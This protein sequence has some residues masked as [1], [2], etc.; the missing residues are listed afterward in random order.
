MEPSD[1]IQKVA[2][3]TGASSGI[4]AATASVLSSRG[5]ALV[6]VA[7]RAE[8][9]EAVAA[10]LPG[11][12]VVVAMD[13]TRMEAPGASIKAAMARFGRLDCL[14]NN[15]G[16]GSPKPLHKTSDEEFDLF[17]DVHLRA[18]FRFCREALTVMTA[19][20]SIVNLAS[21]VASIGGLHC[22]AYSAAKAGVIGLTLHMAAEYG[23]RSIRSNVVSPGITQTDMVMAAWNSEH[24][25]RLNFEQTPL[26][27][28]CKPEDVANTIAFLCS[29]DSAMMNGQVLAVDGGWSTTKYLSREALTAKRTPEG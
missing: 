20:G 7:R 21:T 18:T 3:I 4:G 25:R 24:F 22:S 15:A 28:V 27:R 8:A 13:V 12:S 16:I 17:I 2:L 9:L 29:D 11:P 14:V 6:L 26:P 1:K 23:P 5:F 10:S 19:G